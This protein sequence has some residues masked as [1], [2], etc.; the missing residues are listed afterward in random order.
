MQGAERRRQLA[1]RRIVRQ[2]GLRFGQRESDGP[3]VGA[4]AEAP[5]SSRLRPSRWPLRNSTTGFDSGASEK[6]SIE[7]PRPAISAREVR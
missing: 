7:K 1:A 3:G 5:D 2:G 4:V 6:R